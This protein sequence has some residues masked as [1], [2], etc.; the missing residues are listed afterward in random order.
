M[1][2]LLGSGLLVGL[3][4][5]LVAC[6][7]PVVEYQGVVESVEIGNPTWILV[8]DSGAVLYARGSLPI[9]VGKEYIFLV[10]SNKIRTVKPVK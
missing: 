9:E 2:K 3:F 4:L 6:A 10:Q 1:K 8:L 7:S 5:L